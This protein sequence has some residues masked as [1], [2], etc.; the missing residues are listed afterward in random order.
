MD[1]KDLFFRIKLFPGNGVP[2]TPFFSGK[3]INPLDTP[4]GM[5]LAVTEVLQDSVEEQ[6]HNIFKAVVIGE[7]G[8]GSF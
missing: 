2:A 4:P 1:D 3:I 8:D 5:K 7:A 6:N